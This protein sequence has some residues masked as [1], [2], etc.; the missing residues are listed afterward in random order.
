MEYVA[1]SAL[2]DENG[3]PFSAH[4]ERALR[5]V[6]PKLLRQFA[7]LRD[8]VVI[9]EILEEA[10]RKIVH[11]E[12]QVGPIDKLHGYTWVTVRS[13]AMTRMRRGAMRVA[14]ATLDPEESRAALNGLS[15][16]SGT[17][18]RIE[19]NIRYRQVLKHLTPEEQLLCTLK[20]FGYSSRE[21][22]RQQGTSVAGVNTFF[23]RVKQKILAALGEQRAA[24]PETTQAAERARTRTA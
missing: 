20:R 17:P 23:H 19:S 1:K 16:D 4:V 12:Q 7:S 6:T 13:I 9:V 21:I 3:Q 8:E 11:H 10:G 18:E 24:E 5:E 15:S 2:V 14:R 22:A